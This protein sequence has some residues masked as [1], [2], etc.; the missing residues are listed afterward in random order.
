VAIGTGGLAIGEWEQLP[1]GVL[2]VTQSTYLATAGGNVGIGTNSPKA[3]LDI[4]GNAILGYASDIT[5]FGSPLKSGFYQNAGQEIPGDVPDTSH[6]WTHLITARHSNTAKNHQ[7]QISA[8]YSS[9]DRLFFRKIAVGLETSNPNWNELATRGSNTFSGNQIFVND[10]EHLQLQRSRS[11]TGGKKLFL[12]LVQND[13]GPPQVPECNPCIRFHH[14]SRYWH[15]IE[16][17]GNGLHF[18]DGDLN[19]DN[20]INV[21]AKD[22]IKASDSSLKE[23]V[24]NIEGILDRAMELKP[25]N[26]TWKFNNTNDIGFVAQDVEQ[27]FPELVKSTKIDQEGMKE[28]KCLSY[29]SFGVIAI[30]AIQELKKAYDEQIKTL[31]AKVAELCK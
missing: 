18:K 20:Y 8:S 13:S 26:F 10:S 7:L 28:I 11:E 15:R 5:N 25:I 9:N 16:G 6:A 14:G 21:Y 22:F 17:S 12:E 23:N 2:K 31:E 3:K 4:E 30:A 27:I 24:S 1:Q 29:S 19:V